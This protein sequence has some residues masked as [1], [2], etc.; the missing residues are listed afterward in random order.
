MILFKIKKLLF[1]SLL[2]P[3]FFFFFFFYVRLYFI[4]FL[5]NL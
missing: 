1:E 2:N 3:F 4:I 5:L